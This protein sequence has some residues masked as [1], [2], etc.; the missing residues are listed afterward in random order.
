MSATITGKATVHS[1][2]GDIAYTSMDA[3]AKLEV[4]GSD[5]TH[6]ADVQK[7]IGA[8]GEHVGYRVTN[9]RTTIALELYPTTVAT[10]GTA[11]NAKKALL[12]LPIPCT[13]TL[14]NFDEASA[15]D[16]NGDYIYEGGQKD[17][18]TP[19]GYAKISIEVVRYTHAT[20]STL[21]ATVS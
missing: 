13:I 8:N 14:S 17:S 21:L 18:R 2:A 15:S 11:A 1:L 10:P 3:A 19:D 6:T 7:R 12:K 16:I 9:T 20:A 4:A 5:I